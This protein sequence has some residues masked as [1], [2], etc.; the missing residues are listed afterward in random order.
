MR[1]AVAVRGAEAWQKD[2][3]AFHPLQVPRPCAFASCQAVSEADGTPV[4]MSAQIVDVPM[5]PSAES[6]M[7]GDARQ[8]S[9]GTS[10]AADIDVVPPPKL[11]LPKSPDLNADR[12]GAV[13]HQGVSARFGL[14]LRAGRKPSLFNPHSVV[15]PLRAP[16][17]IAC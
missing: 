14:N 8:K 6:S 1:A 3:R 15:V 12:T 13:E 11:H 4:C 7:V 16:N 2:H 5:Q 17:P 9:P 10:G